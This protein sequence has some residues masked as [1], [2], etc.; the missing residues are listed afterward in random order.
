[1]NDGV[2]SVKLANR[3]GVNGET[4]V[5][6]IVFVA[7]KIGLSD[8]GECTLAPFRYHVCNSVFIQKKRGQRFWLSDQ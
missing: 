8:T 3:L 4:M 5:E 6:I 2:V 1:M 7:P